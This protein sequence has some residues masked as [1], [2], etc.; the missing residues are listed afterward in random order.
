MLA[1]HKQMI[2]NVNMTRK[3][4]LMHINDRRSTHL[5]ESMGTH[6]FKSHNPIT[7]PVN[8]NQNP[9]IQQEMQSVQ[10]RQLPDDYLGKKQSLQFSSSQVMNQLME[11]EYAPSKMDTRN[12]SMPLVTIDRKGNKPINDN[13]G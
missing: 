2:G 11:P 13:F 1:H 4:P 6:K 5:A 8:I 10:Y 9:F 7:N 12:Q 3:Q